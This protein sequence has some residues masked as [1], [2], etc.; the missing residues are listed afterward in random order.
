MS[1]PLYNLYQLLYGAL[2]FFILQVHAT[3]QL[4]P[5]ATLQLRLFLQSFI[6][7]PTA[8]T[9]PFGGPIGPDQGADNGPDR[10]EE[11]EL[12]FCFLN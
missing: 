4:R 5:C 1:I 6:Q 7:L 2:I 3:M 9:V 10:D 12:A 8:P 11:Y